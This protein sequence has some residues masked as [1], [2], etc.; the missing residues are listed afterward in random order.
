MKAYPVHTICA[1]SATRFLRSLT[2]F[3]FS[4]FAPRMYQALGIGL[5]GLLCGIPAPLVIWYY[6]AKLRAK[7]Y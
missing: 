2:V 1:G 3:L 7:A 4:L 5:I 6:G